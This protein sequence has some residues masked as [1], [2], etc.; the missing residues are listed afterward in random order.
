MRIA[1][2]STD[3]GVPILGTK[4]ASVH[5]RQVVEALTRRGHEVLV[6]TPNPGGTPTRPTTFA[7]TAL[8]FDEIPALLHDKLKEE[9]ICSGNRLPKD[10]RNIFYSLWVEDRA[11]RLLSEFQP[12]VVYERYALFGTAGL[13]IARRLSVPLLVEVNAP[14]VEEQQEQRGLCLSRVATAAQRLVFTRAD[15]LIVV[16]RWLVPYAESHGALP[17]HITVVPNAA[18]PELFHPAPEASEI[19]RRLG[20][21]DRIVL[22]FVGAMKPWQGVRRLVDSL[23]KLGPDFRLLLVGDGPDLDAVR[24]RVRELQLDDA[25]HCTGAVPHEEV[26]AWLG[27]ADIALVPYEATAAQYF[28]PVKLFEYMSMGLPIVAARIA[29]TEEILAHGEQGWLYSASDPSEPAA[30]LRQLAADLPAAR[31]IGARARQHVL[32]HHTWERNAER[33]E[34][35]AQR[36]LGRAR[37]IPARQL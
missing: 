11:V 37:S 8:P 15:E 26:P 31:R 22:V 2:L 25:V 6:L 7:M 10:L 30:T 3:F 19:R 27:A 12:D 34:Q 36:A 32:A 14:L 29:Q 18:D 17:A 35:L 9:A 13:E 4:G 33:V 5:V 23:A 21:D 20:W 1:Y 16:S 24:A 28:S